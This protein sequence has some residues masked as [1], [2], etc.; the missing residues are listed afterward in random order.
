MNDGD[1]STRQRVMLITGGSRGI[2]AA[3]AVLA[4]RDGYDVA[5][6]YRQG[7]DEAAAVCRQVEAAGRRALAVAADLALEADIERLWTTALAEFGSV[8]ALVNNAGILEQQMPVARM[9]G[10]RLQRIFAVNT[11]GSILCARE[12]VRHMS[13]STGGAGGVIVNVSSIAAKLGSPGEYV[14][15]AASKAAIDTFTI[16]LAKEVGGD[17]IRVNSVRPG[18]IDTGM[19]AAGGEP[20]RVARVAKRVPMQRGGRADEIAEVIVWLCSDKASYVNGA[21]LEAGGGL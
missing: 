11:F 8:S 7:A 15:Y 10:A 13:Q 6:S 3:T 16:G 2:G 20:E 19:H 17:G 9:D 12:A 5:L 14:D 18:T 1:D 21:I 4:A